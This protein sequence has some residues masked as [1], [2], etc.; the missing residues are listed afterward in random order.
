MRKNSYKN[1]GN[2]SSS[3]LYIPHNSFSYQKSR[4]KVQ[5]NVVKP[6]ELK[7]VCGESNEINGEKIVLCPTAETKICCF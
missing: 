1:L 3:V 2:F 6:Q 4:W 7:M 5:V